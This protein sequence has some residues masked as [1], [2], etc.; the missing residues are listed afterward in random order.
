MI[1]WINELPLLVNVSI[2]ASV[3][4]VAVLLARLI[5]R[6]APKR[7]VCLLWLLVL[8]RLLCPFAPKASFSAF[9]PVVAHSERVEEQQAVTY[10]TVTVPASPKTNILPPISEHTPIMEAEPTPVSE[11]SLSIDPLTLIWASGAVIFL[12]ISLI[13]YIKTMRRTVPS[14]KIS[15]GVY[16]AD[17]IETAFVTGLIRPRVYL[18]STLREEEREYILLHER[19]HVK[20]L[21]HLFKL[22][23]Y[24]AL[25]VHWFNP[26]V[27]LAFS[28][29]CSDM[30][31][32]CDEAV[33]DK[34]G[35]TVIPDY[36]QS[37]LDLSSSRRR[38]TPSPLAFGEGD[39]KRRIKR[40]LSWKRPGLIIT[41]VCVLIVA[42]LAA[43]L[44][45]NPKE[46]K[47]TE[48]EFPE[49]TG[50]AEAVH[51][52]EAYRNAEI[53][54]TWSS[55]AEPHILVAGIREGTQ[56]GYVVLSFDKESG[57]A[58]HITGGMGEYAVN[59][60]LGKADGLSVPLTIAAC[61][62]P[63]VGI[64]EAKYK[65][66]TVRDNVTDCPALCV[67]V[68]SDSYFE[69]ENFAPEVSFLSP[70]GEELAGFGET[71]PG[72]T[73]ADTQISRGD[74]L[75]QSIVGAELA[76]TG[77]NSFTFNDPTEL[78]SNELYMLFLYFS[79][80]DTLKKDCMDSDGIFTFTED[81][82][83]SFLHTYFKDFSLDISILTDY[84]PKS[85][86][87]RTVQASG[88]GGD[89]YVE[90]AEQHEDGNVLTVTM[91]YYDSKEREGAVWQRKTYRLE[92]YE[93][94][95]YFLSAC[96]DDGCAEPCSYYDLT[97]ANGVKLGMS[98][99]DVCGILG[100]ST[101][102]K[103][104]GGQYEPGAEAVDIIEE[105]IH[106]HFS[107]CECGLF[108]LR[109]VSTVGE[110][111]AEVMP[112]GIRTGMSSDEVP[113]ILNA[114]AIDIVLNEEGEIVRD[115]RPIAR[116][117]AQSGS[118]T[119]WIQLP[120][121]EIMFDIFFDTENRVR[122]FDLSGPLSPDKYIHDL[123]GLS[124]VP[125]GDSYI[126]NVSFVSNTDLGLGHVTQ[127]NMLL[128]EGSEEY[129]LRYRYKDT[130]LDAPVRYHHAAVTCFDIDSDGFE[131]Q[132]FRGLTADLS[133]ET[134]VFKLTKDGVIT[135]WEHIPG[136]PTDEH[137]GSTPEGTYME[138]SSGVTLCCAD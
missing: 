72:D 57:E 116:Y 5:L 118:G 7:A 67:F 92:L 9:T 89:R 123:S 21:D 90:I 79:E 117:M 44:L 98:Y 86:A 52:V 130:Y 76:L 128:L 88:F 100:I 136:R 97:L 60:T 25:C 12:V 54:S 80:Y 71:I 28:L 42:V 78:S 124:P 20:R 103:D 109:S 4:I 95:F 15:K 84:D 55:D 58:I 35:K 127:V 133:E 114:D 110:G 81:Y 6:R 131:E 96:F 46:E 13:R 66:H 51:S 132:F 22:L 10:N 63:S 16:M 75:Y 120:S 53:F 82:I 104:Y 121:G 99:E 73:P 2:T 64:I 29:L 19:T 119:L 61:Y 37:L 48:P 30:E 33:L 138:F 27:W 106:Y 126:K 87:I 24:V 115:G 39:P 50:I 36:A 45:T 91:N 85:G 74:D 83:S 40:V 113:S 94:G 23:F 14:A 59:V 122:H 43:V 134:T 26:L 17:R 137:T 68:W 102:F 62:D 1:N 69:D 107:R 38:F 129:V 34:L 31:M 77:K 105:G 93:G 108:H 70:D 18:P 65:N 112:L 111:Y 56:V 49:P 8:I 32:A 3:V 41:A 125:C 101:K 135:L 47:M 11:K